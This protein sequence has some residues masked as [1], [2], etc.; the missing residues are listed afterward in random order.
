MKPSL[1]IAARTLA[2]DLATGEVVRALEAAGIESMLLKGPAM[3]RRLY[4]DEPGAR[5]YGDI[6]L[7]V[8]PWRFGDAGHVLA[9]LGFTD[10]RAG[11]RASEAA[12]LPARP[13]HR[14]GAAYVAV[15]LH[16]GFRHV[17]DW[18]TWW[19]LLRRERETLELE[20]QPVA[21]PGRVGCALIAVLHASDPSAPDKPLEDLRRA[22]GRFDDELWRQAADLAQAVGAAGAFAGTLACL[23]AG[24]A[25]VSRLGLPVTD[26]TGWFL[27][28]SR[29]R[30]TASLGVVLGPGTWA[31]RAQRARDAAIPS[32]A[33]LAR[34]W[35]IAERGRCGLV[36]AHCGRLCVAAASLPPLLL[37]WHRTSRTLR[38]RAAAGGRAR[39]GLR[40]RARGAAGTG[41]WTLRTWWL[42]R[43]RLRRGPWRTGALPPPVLP[44]VPGAPFSGRM[45][46]LVLAGCRA[47]CLEA[48]LIRQARAAD[49]GQAADVIVGIT[50]PA[51]GFRAHAWLAGDRVD[52]GFVEL[53]RYSPV[54]AQAG[55]ARSDSFRPVRCRDR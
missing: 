17:A 30:G 20:G 34:G 9:S 28:T 6:D 2:L 37:A 36:V 31:A 12:R 38:H 45:A 25:L 19:D 55:P 51:S 33:D 23:D 29:L 54:V 14:D 48:A 46:R 21:I 18:L 10:R 44:P 39:R 50:A 53:C 1:G 27:A 8:A 13:W 49:A 26:H 43:R 22:L 35:P 11:L 32:R 5:N 16:R 52:P 15:D 42:I 41:W 4:G 3:A 7:L 40:A 47:S 24:A